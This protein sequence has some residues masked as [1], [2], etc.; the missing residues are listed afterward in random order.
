VLGSLCMCTSMSRLMRKVRAVDYN[1]VNFAWEVEEV[2]DQINLN[3]EWA[4]CF[5]VFM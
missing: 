1:S 3:H 4:L 2:R 5:F